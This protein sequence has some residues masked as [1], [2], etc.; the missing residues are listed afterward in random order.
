MWFAREL[1][2][3]LLSLLREAYAVVSAAS[4]SWLAVPSVP[5]LLPEKNVH[6]VRYLA[7]FLFPKHRDCLKSMRKYKG[8]SQDLPRSIWLY[9]GNLGAPYL[10][11]NVGRALRES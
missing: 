7:I 11:E 9:L 5:A 2:I 6:I 1:E 10:D 4:F 3:K 8:D